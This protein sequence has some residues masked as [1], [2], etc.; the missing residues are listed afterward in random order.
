M[1]KFEISIYVPQAWVGELINSVIFLTPWSRLGATAAG[2]EPPRLPA[3][4]PSKLLFPHGGYVRGFQR[5]LRKLMLIG[6]AGGEVCGGGGMLISSRV[7]PE[8]E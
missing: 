3:P 5:R 1:I 4:H 6:R 8:D 7:H 2:L